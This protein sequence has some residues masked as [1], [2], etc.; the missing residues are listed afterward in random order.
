VTTASTRHPQ[1]RGSREAGTWATA[2]ALDATQFPPPRCSGRLTPWLSPERRSLARRASFGGVA[3]HEVPLDLGSSMPR[4]EPIRS[5]REPSGTLDGAALY[6]VATSLVVPRPDSGEQNQISEGH[7]THLAPFS[8]FTG[9]DD[10]D[11]RV[12]GVDSVP[13]ATGDT[14]TL[15]DNIRQTAA[16]AVHCVDDPARPRWADDTSPATRFYHPATMTFE[17][18]GPHSSVPCTPIAPRVCRDCLAACLEHC[19]AAR[20]ELPVPGIHFTHWRWGQVVMVHRARAFAW[21]PSG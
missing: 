11:R 19:D 5:H 9:R 3:A 15:P 14:D 1:L 8:F 20:A 16:F 21:A 6:P 10:S 18:A 7:S 2:V 13:G 4:P 17:A 12:N